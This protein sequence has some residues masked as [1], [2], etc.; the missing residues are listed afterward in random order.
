MKHS[1]LL[2][3]VFFIFQTH[4]NA[5]GVPPSDI[6]EVRKNKY[7]IELGFRSI[8]SIW[9][10]TTSGTIIFKHRVRTGDL[11]DVKAVKYVRGFLSLGSQVN[12]DDDPSRGAID[13]SQTRFH[14][15]NATRGTIGLGLEKQFEIKNFVHYHGVD[16]AFTYYKSDD[17]FVS[18][19]TWGGVQ[20]NGTGTTD[21]LIR[22][23]RA[24]LTP[25]VGV[26]YYLGG[27]FSLGIETG[28]SVSYYNTKITELRRGPNGLEELPSTTSNG[29]QFD[30]LGIRN[31]LIGYAF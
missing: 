28:L 2:F 31:V 30:F 12:F 5:Q 8:E 17:D 20:F 13:S 15:G 24:G 23:A 10:S 16:A 19:A 22:T 14:P 7:Q 26:K 4:A 27:R 21:R 6:S 18:N 3:V 29:I 9:K 11:I 1:M 25:F